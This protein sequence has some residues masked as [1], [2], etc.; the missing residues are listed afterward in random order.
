V[1]ERPYFSALN[2]AR[3]ISQGRSSA[4]VEW[5]ADKYSKHNSYRLKGKTG[6]K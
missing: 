6:T 3:R 2:R 1:I 4:K 5:D